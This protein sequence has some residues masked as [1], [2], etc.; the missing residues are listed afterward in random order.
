MTGLKNDE[1]WLRTTIK[2][3]CLNVVAFDFFDEALAA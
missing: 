1:R 2:F 3:L